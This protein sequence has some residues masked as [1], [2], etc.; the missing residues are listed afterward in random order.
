MALA[1]S[2]HLCDVDKSTVVLEIGEVVMTICPQ[3]P[4]STGTEGNENL[5]KPLPV[6][7]AAAVIESIEK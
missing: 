6:L 2:C 4:S 3:I 7:L 1:R 5:T